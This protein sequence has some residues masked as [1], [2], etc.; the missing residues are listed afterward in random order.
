MS[1]ACLPFE[2][3]ILL[4]IYTAQPSPRFCRSITADSTTHEIAETKKLAAVERMKSGLQQVHHESQTHTYLLYL[5]HTRVRPQSEQGCS[6][7][8]LGLFSTWISCCAESECAE[9]VCIA[10]AHNHAIGIRLHS[11]LKGTAVQ[12]QGAH[13]RLPTSQGGLAACTHGKI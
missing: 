9:R 4:Q 5:I 6:Q 13:S 3:L 2:I 10:A 7:L 12:H 8:N 1:R 11:A